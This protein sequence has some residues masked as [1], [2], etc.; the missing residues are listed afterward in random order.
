MF[1]NYFSIFFVFLKLGFSSFGGPIAHIGYFHN[2]FVKQRKWLDEDHYADLVALCHFLPGPSS[3][4][5][6]MAIGFYRLGF[7]GAIVAWFGFTLPA[8]TIMT[9]LALGVLKFNNNLPIELLNGLKIAVV[10]VV[11]QAVYLMGKKLCPNLKTLF[12]SIISA[13]VAI[14]FTSVFT[15]LLTLFMAGLTGAILLKNSD[16]SKHT[17]FEINLSK[18][19]GSLFLFLFLFVLLFTPI[20]ANQTELLNMKLFEGFYRV[21]SLI[22]GGGHVVL[23]FLKSITV[24]SNLVTSENFLVGYGLAQAIPGPL[25]SFASYLGASINGLSGATFCLI[26]I[27]LPSFFLIIGVLPFWERLRNI[28]KF[29]LSLMGVNASVVGLL[30]AALYNPIWLESIV[31][32]ND[33][34][35]FLITLTITLYWKLPSW[36]IVSVCII[37]KTSTLMFFT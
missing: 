17:L 16:R 11:T 29:K 2:E 26:A 28:Q 22:F 6:G 30:S 23:P 36:M 9:L 31:S 34:Y 10:V 25:F 1:K 18:K 14:F 13:L 27:F 12:I 35:I 5:V 4:Q 15:Q 24:D 21:G 8:A 32:L 7:L 37:L 3:S 19:Q 33:F 20:I